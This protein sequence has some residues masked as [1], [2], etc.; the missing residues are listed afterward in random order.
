M[1]IRLA[2]CG[3]WILTVA[4]AILL[5]TTTLLVLEPSLAD[6]IAAYLGP[7]PLTRL[8]RLLY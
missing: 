5:A 7:G 3:L 8:V 6:K 4:V 1:K 2:V